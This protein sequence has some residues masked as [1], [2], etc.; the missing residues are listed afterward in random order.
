MPVYKETWLRRW[1]LL[2]EQKEFYGDG[3]S[4]L[5]LYNDWFDLIEQ[6]GVSNHLLLNANDSEET[7]IPF[8]PGIANSLITK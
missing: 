3:R 6:E 5:G 1:Y 4:I 7:A 8:D 2:N